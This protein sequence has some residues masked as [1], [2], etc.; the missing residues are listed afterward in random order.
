[1]VV[2]ATSPSM[3][4]FLRQ[5]P[6]LLALLAILALQGRAAA[7]LYFACEVMDGCPM[8][9]MATSEVA[10]PSVP[11]VAVPDFSPVAGDDHSCCITTPAV[12]APKPAVVVPQGDADCDH[13]LRLTE[14]SGLPDCCIVRPAPVESAPLPPTPDA[15]PVLSPCLFPPAVTVDVPLVRPALHTLTVPDL[16]PPWLLDAVHDRAARGPPVLR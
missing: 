5:F 12:P 16:R 10:Q 1:M 8:P 6:A 14:T 15:A 13:L 7:G 9:S 2:R 3:P 11:A 4:R